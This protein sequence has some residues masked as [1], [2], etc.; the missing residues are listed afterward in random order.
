[1]RIP[2]PLVLAVVAISAVNVKNVLAEQE[3]HE[4]HTPFATTL[5]NPCNGI[6]VV[7]ISGTLTTMI[8]ET[9]SE[10]GNTH[11]GI[12]VISKGNGLGQLS[13][14]NYTYSE[15]FYSG[16][17]ASGTS[18]MTQ[19]MNHRLTSAGSTDNFYMSLRYHLTLTPNGV[20]TAMVDRF[21]AG[22]RG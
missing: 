4:I 6:D 16:L 5:V 19:I 7:A 9:V 15:E 1:M 13:E 10:S 21:E 14:V 20:P 17:N 2:L 3:V 18:T 12:H 8:Q 22:C 11:S